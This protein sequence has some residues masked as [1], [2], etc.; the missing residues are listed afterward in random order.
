MISKLIERLLKLRNKIQDKSGFTLIEL[1]VVIVIV[2]IL[3]LA[4]VPFFKKTVE[5]AKYSEGVTAIGALQTKI[6]VYIAKEGKL[7]GVGSAGESVVQGALG[8][9]VLDKTIRL[10]SAVAEGHAILIADGS[11]L[12]GAFADKNYMQS[13][14][15]IDYDEYAGK[16]FKTH[17]FQYMLQQQVL[18]DGSYA[19]A[20]AV[21][22]IGN[23]AD[24]KARASS[25]Y[26]V[27]TR[28]IGTAVVGA[29]PFVVATYEDY[30]GSDTVVIKK[31][32]TD[33]AAVQAGTIRCPAYNAV[34]VNI[35][36]AGTTV[37]WKI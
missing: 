6:K 27:F 29:T 1:M 19:Y 8:A 33:T 4:V 25:A 9:N 32:L 30:M 14:L 18:A 37:D 26:A 13:A 2:V 7:P 15:E 36:K 20:L 34:D 17:H 5:E 22:P 24:S 28:Y 35:S 3:A 12:A 21:A 23:T 16:S 31:I 11:S 10:V